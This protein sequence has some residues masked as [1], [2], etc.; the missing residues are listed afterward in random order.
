ML[1]Q[2]MLIGSRLLPQI[3]IPFFLLT[4]V[5]AQ[6]ESKTSGDMRAVVKQWIEAEKTLSS[7]AVAWKQEQI[8]MKDLVDVLKQDINTLNEEMAESQERFDDSGKQRDELLSR[9]DKDQKQQKL[10]KDFLNILEPRLLALR[11]QLPEP[12]KNPL[13]AMYQRVPI[14]GEE[15][16]LGIAERTQ[17]VLAIITTIRAFDNTLTVARE[18]R[19]LGGGGKQEVTTLYVGLAQAFYVSADDAGYG[20]PRKDGWAWTSQPQLE[21]TLRRTNDMV[22]GTTHEVDY[23]TLPLNISTDR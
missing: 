7:E 6:E 16:T 17:T 12:L 8:L 11:P 19:E 22:E 3:C 21:K 18:L 9:S 2:K 20:V 14:A 5:E 13:A 1:L 15:T 4:G 23:V 10:V